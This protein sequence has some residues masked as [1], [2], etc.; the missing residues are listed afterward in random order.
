MPLQ[1]SKA[2]VEGLLEALR[3]PQTA[4]SPFTGAEVQD[5]KEAL[6]EAYRLYERKDQFG[7]LF[8][9]NGVWTVRAG[10]PTANRANEWAT[11]RGLE[12]GTATIV[13][14]RSAD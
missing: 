1:P 9:V 6:T 7:I 8:S 12:P 3:G 13:P 14:V 10:F 5:A 4:E 2:D 11:K